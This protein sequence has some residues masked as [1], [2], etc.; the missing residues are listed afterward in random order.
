MERKWTAMA[1]LCCGFGLAGA[2][3]QAPQF[4]G[5][6]S[7]LKPAQKALVDRWVA[8]YR[9]IFKRNLNAQQTYDR[10]PLSAR[11]TFEAVTHALSRTS[12]TTSSGKSLGT[13]LDL[14][15]MVE[16]VAGNVPG[17][18]GDEQF[19]V[20][21]YL[22][23]GATGKL[24]ASREFKR[25]RDNTVFHIG[26]PLNFRETGGAPSIQIS[27]AND[28][29]RADIDVDYRP[30]GGPSA[31]FNGH[32]TAANSDVRAGD[33]YLRHVNRWQGFSDW[34]RQLLAGFS[35]LPH[36][37]A[38]NLTPAVG[39]VREK[40]AHGPLQDAIHLYLTNWLIHQQPETLLPVISVKAFP[41]VAEFKDG[42]RPDSR[43]AH[44]RILRRMM[45]QNKMLGK[46][47][48]LEDVVQ[49][50]EY[51]LPGAQVVQQPYQSLFSI[52]QVPDDVA[53]AMDCRLRYKLD[54]VEALPRPEHKLGG[55]YVAT[56]RIKNPTEPAAFLVET[57]RQESGEWRLVS[58]DIK[59][60]SKPPDMSVVESA[61]PPPAD[62]SPGMAL[63]TATRLLTSWFV[64]RNVEQ[65]ATYFLPSASNCDPYAVRGAAPAKPAADQSVL[66]KFLAEASATALKKNRLEQ[67]I[68]A[69]EAGH[70]GLKPNSHKLSRAFLIGSVSAEL[71]NSHACT[72]GRPKPASRQTSTAGTEDVLTAFR[73]IGGDKGENPVISLYWKKVQG[74]WRVASY[75]VAID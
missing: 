28:G 32:L 71:M 29:L 33:N 26:Y 65:A 64:D 55:T 53:W 30:S 58:F 7:N 15:D 70:P 4:G 11:T 75:D 18:R 67:I 51:P 41:C 66:K 61:G 68:A 57:W 54:M 37:S 62:P 49:P 60:H 45:E 3:T 59:R 12:L 14:V 42:S 23:R 43:L 31:L 56:M 74:G 20:W 36:E 21:V 50:V 17:T 34:W 40:V 25:D 1:V 44:L 46:V 16:R 19:R 10:F 5:K 39:E 52:Q 73:L 22:K 13:A 9:V 47:N 6:Y 72:T 48:R 69:P 2:Q 38:Q 8:E 27:V 63:D 24:Y 35:N